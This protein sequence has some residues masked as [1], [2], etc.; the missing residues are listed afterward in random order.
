M[1]AAIP[2]SP[3]SGKNQMLLHH[4]A[5]HLCYDVYSKSSN[6]QTISAKNHNVTCKQ[7]LPSWENESATTQCW[8]SWIQRSFTWLL[9]KLMM[10]A[11]C[12]QKTW[13]THRHKNCTRYAQTIFLKNK[14]NQQH[15]LLWHKVVLA[16]LQFHPSPVSS[17]YVA[18][19]WSTDQT[20]TVNI[21]TNAGYFEVQHNH[22]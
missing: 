4:H 18:H 12:G 21:Q 5:A 19:T 1:M 2:T 17:P 8:Y 22:Y 9:M 10:L 13:R 20:L 6:V 11:T 14:E 16:S 7:N 3:V 15:M